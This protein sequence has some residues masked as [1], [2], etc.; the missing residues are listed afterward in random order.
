MEKEGRL[1]ASPTT[2][3]RPCYNLDGW[4]AGKGHVL[5]VSKRLQGLFPETADLTAVLFPVCG[6]LVKAGG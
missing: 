2:A 4:M 5:I 1:L 3:G 6:G